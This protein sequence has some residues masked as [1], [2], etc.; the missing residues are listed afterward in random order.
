SCR[1]ELSPPPAE[2]LRP[3]SPKNL[4][5]SVFEKSALWNS[6]SFSTQWNLRDIKRNKART[7]MGIIGVAGCTM[8]MLAAFGC[9][10]SI[11]FI[12]DWMYGEL[13]TCSYQIIMESF[14]PYSDVYDYAKK[15]KGQMMENES[16]DFRFN[17]IKK[18]GTVSIIDNGNYMHFQ[19]EDYSHTELTQSG[20]AMSYK[21]AQSLGMR[22]G[23]FVTWNL[24]GD[25][26]VHTDRIVQIYRNPGTQGITMRRKVYEKHEY[27]FK[28]TIIMT[29]M[30]P[31]LDL[32]EDNNVTGVQ[33]TSEM[34]ESMDKMKE[35]MYMMMGILISAAVILG[36]VVLYNL[37]VLSFVEK[38]KEMATLKVLG[39]KS[40]KIRGILGQQNLWVTISGTLLGIPL[41]ILLLDGIMSDMPE[42]MDYQGIIYAPSYFYS[43][44]GTFALSIAVSLFLSR[45]V[46]TIDMVDALKGQ[47]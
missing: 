41:G 46:N 43:V 18:T 11:N 39:F 4:K 2:T 21:M 19:D 38:T 29:N 30:D 27:K 24:T 44:I 25:D 20:I 40:R 22:K 14:V 9:L 37:G 28:P 13:N 32:K 5:P 6:F 17:G 23:D 10:D 12:T 47:E 8:L 1:R 15:Y 7:G 42:S 3:A 31:S 45:K 36:V 35:M 34:M 33:N 26:E 16:A